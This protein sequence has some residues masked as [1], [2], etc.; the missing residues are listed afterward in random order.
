MKK[1]IIALSII[2]VLGLTS[3]TG[4]QST[5]S[6]GA[7]NVKRSQ[8]LTVDS[9]EFN[10]EIDK[11]Y[12]A[13]LSKARNAGALDVPAA[14][15]KRVSNIFQRM[16][17]HTVAFRPDGTKFNWEIHTINSSTVNASCYAGGK[18]VV[19]TGIIDQLNLDD[20]ELAAIVGHE[21]AH[22]LREHSRE[23]FS[24]QQAKSMG[25]SVIKQVTNISGSQLQLAE[26]V[27]QFGMSLPFS[28]TMESESDVIGLELMARAGYNPEAAPR[29]WRKMSKLSGSQGSSLEAI[30]STHPTNE[31]RIKKLESLIPTVMPLYEES[32]LKKAPTTKRAITKGKKR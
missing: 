8:L 6:G 32:K 26:I 28:R 31:A 27:S 18:M 23:Q 19:Y 10:A 25:F 15:A 16:L 11:Y 20:D 24:Q 14:K 12:R 5:T 17:P 21:M 4:C 29:V 2:T 22:A 3:L 7:T 1:N 13:E 30:T 9:A